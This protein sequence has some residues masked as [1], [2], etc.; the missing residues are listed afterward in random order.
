MQDYEGRRCCAFTGSFSRPW[1]LLQPSS[2]SLSMPGS[3]SAAHLLS[4]AEG[5]SAGPC[6]QRGA[7]SAFFSAEGSSDRRRPGSCAAA[8]G[9]IFCL[10]NAWEA[11]AGEIGHISKCAGMFHFSWSWMQQE[12]DATRLHSRCDSEVAC[13]SKCGSSKP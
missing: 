10:P 12:R 8:D 11:L 6:M 1:Q 9:I 7:C 2:L 13:S 4:E 5:H 3:T